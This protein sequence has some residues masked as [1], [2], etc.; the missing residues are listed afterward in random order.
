MARRRKAQGIAKGGA[1]DAASDPCVGVVSFG[2]GLR[3]EA[4]GGSRSE[5]QVVVPGAAVGGVGGSD[6]RRTASL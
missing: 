5:R 6:A 2:R 4:R 1:A 3:T